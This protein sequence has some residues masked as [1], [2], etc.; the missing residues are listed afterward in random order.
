MWHPRPLWTSNI[1]PFV[2]FE[3]NEKS[4]TKPNRLSRQACLAMPRYAVLCRAMPR[5]HNRITTNA[6]RMHTECTH[7]R[8][9]CTHAYPY[10]HMRSTHA[11][12]ACI[13][14]FCTQTAHRCTHMLA[15]EPAKSQQLNPP[16]ESRRCRCHCSRHAPNVTLMFSIRLDATATFASWMPQRALS[17]GCHG[18]L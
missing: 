11:A 4:M 5:M 17:L 6:R 7:A 9:A 2:P 8:H 3:A 10:I 18:D 15:G 16:Q 12:G 13:Q 1:V 14:P